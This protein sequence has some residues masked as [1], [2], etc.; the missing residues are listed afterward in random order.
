MLVYTVAKLICIR[1][2]IQT[3]S[4]RISVLK[5]VELELQIRLRVADIPI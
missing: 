3:M 1:M 5:G 2:P 4:S